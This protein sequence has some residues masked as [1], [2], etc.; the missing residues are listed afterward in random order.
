MVNYPKLNLALRLSGKSTGI[1]VSKIIRKLL[2][3]SQITAAATLIFINII[4]FSSSV[5]TLYEPLGFKVKDRISANLFFSDEDEVTTNEEKSVIL[6]NIKN[7][8]LMLPQ[9]ES[10]ERSDS[11]M[12]NKRVFKF[13][14]PVSNK[15]FLPEPTSVSEGYFSILEQPLLEGDYFSAEDIRDNNLVVIINNVFAK[16]LSPA[17]S[18][19]GMKIS[20]GVHADYTI[21]GV[22]EGA[23][24]PGYKGIPNRIFLPGSLFNT[25][26]LIK[27]KSNHDLTRAEFA[28]LVSSADERF[29]VDQFSH[30]TTQRN[31]LLLSKIMTAITSAVLGLLSLIMAAL[32]LYG[33]LSYG[34][35]MRRFELATRLAIGAKRKDIVLLI[36]KDSL[37]AIFAGILICLTLLFLLYISFSDELLE[38][39]NIGLLGQFSITLSLIGLIS[40]TAC[41]LPLRKI[42]NYPP[43]KALRGIN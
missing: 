21:K 10:V 37:S 12:L 39:I 31:Q 11:P 5:K 35:Q 8:L 22:V 29:S 38:Y 19:L 25:A 4:L 14:E 15:V 42:I 30:L 1:Q 3:V 40:I 24:I 34:I 36:I 23:K 41:Y 43:I 9:V 27:L 13:T 32:G 16:E 26:F 33:V 28:K 2:I 18:V 17:K 6:N 20:D 7:Q